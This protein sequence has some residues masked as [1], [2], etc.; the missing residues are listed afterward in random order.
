MKLLPFLLLLSM[1]AFAEVDSDPL[2]AHSEKRK[3]V[4]DALTETGTGFFNNLKNG[5]TIEQLYKSIEI[6]ISDEDS[7]ALFKMIA[8]IANQYDAKNESESTLHI[9]LLH[10]CV[11]TSGHFYRAFAGLW[12]EVVPIPPRIWGDSDVRIYVSTGC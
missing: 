10:Q 6:E 8:D 4:C 5:S 7:A 12:L 9:D 1:T 3:E 2:V 11:T